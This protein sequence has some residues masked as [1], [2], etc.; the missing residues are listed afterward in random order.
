MVLGVW[1]EVKKYAVFEG[2][3]HG[4]KHTTGLLLGGHE[5]P[6]ALARG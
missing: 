6:R 4:A 5:L 2:S 1:N 3:K